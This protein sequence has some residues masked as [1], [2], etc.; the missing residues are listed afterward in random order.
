MQ[1]PSGNVLMTVTFENEAPSLEECA[2]VL[3]VPAKAIDPGF[4]VVVVDPKRK[5]CTV[6]VAE[7]AVS[8]EAKRSGAVFSDPM[9]APFGPVRND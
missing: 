8:A 9:I 7:D 4:G 6:R 2:R 5:I 3:H 1:K